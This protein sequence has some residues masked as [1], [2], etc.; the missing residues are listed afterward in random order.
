MCQI[1]IFATLHRGVSP[2]LYRAERTM[3]RKSFSW[4][5]HFPKEKHRPSKMG[6]TLKTTE[7]FLQPR[8]P[9]P[10]PPGR[11]ARTRQVMSGDDARQDAGEAM[12][13]SCPWERGEKHHLI[14]KVR[15]VSICQPPI[16]GLN[17]P[18]AEENSQC[19]F[20]TEFISPALS[21]EWPCPA[22][23]S[24]KPVSSTICQRWDG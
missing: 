15:D 1:K 16:A 18:M 2:L 23:R 4:A 9:P 12:Q 24:L 11:E 6:F 19:C 10:I 7:L 8:A 20:N 3:A 21:D 22:Q 17:G 14:L 13:R 5:V